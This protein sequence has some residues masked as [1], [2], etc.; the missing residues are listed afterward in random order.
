[1]PQE[2]VF[3]VYGLDLHRFPDLELQL[4]FGLYKIPVY[5]RCRLDMLH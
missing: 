1:M 5:S 3:G 2:Q 4:M